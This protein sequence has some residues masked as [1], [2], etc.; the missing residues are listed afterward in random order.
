MAKSDELEGASFQKSLL[1][2]LDTLIS[3]IESLETSLDVIQSDI[4]TEALAGREMLHDIHAEVS[5]LSDMQPDLAVVAQAVDEDEK[6]L[7]V[8]VLEDEE[9][10]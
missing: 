9:S 4:T 5:A 1:E 7:R 10:K 8:L 6:A 2:K 3:A